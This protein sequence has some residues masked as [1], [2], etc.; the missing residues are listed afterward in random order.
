MVVL[1]QDHNHHLIQEQ[2]LEVV[3]WL[4][5]QMVA[6]VV[7]EMVV[8]AEVFLTHLV[9]VEKTV[10]HIIILQVVVVVTVQYLDQ[11]QITVLVD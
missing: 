5:A 4:Q 6:Q 8:Q 3:L 11:E 9:Q 10:V 2:V 7:V 1:L